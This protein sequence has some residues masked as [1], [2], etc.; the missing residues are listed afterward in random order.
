MIEKS[1]ENVPVYKMLNN[2]KIISYFKLE[3]NW[4][5]ICFNDSKKQKM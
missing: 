5:S 3:L 1:S 4:I 2:V